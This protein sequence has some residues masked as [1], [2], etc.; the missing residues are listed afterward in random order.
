K[1]GGVTL[2]TAVRL[3]ATFP[4]VSPAAVLPCLPT[5]RVVDAGYYDNHGVDV[6]ASWLMANEKTIMELVKPQPGK[7][8]LVSKVV[9]IE[10]RP[11]LRLDGTKPGVLTAPLT[12]AEFD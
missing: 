6:A 7:K 2:G 10:L 5:R 3:N 8:K 1:A 9:V 4:L 12:Q 11:Y